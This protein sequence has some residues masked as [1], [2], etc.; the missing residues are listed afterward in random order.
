MTT[1][2]ET[3]HSADDEASRTDES[4]SDRPV[5]LVVEDQPAVAET[6][7][8]MLADRYTVRVATD[9]GAAL[10]ALSTGV[11]VVLLDRTMPGISGEEILAEIRDRGSECRMA[12]VTAVEPDVDIVEM[13][14][15]A[16]VQKPPTRAELVATVEDLLRRSR[17]AAD[18]RNYCTALSKQATLAAAEKPMA[19]HPEYAT[20]VADIEATG[21]R[22][23]A[24]AVDLTDDMAFLSV[25]RH[26][27][28]TPGVDA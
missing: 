18:L 11:D 23:Q 1:D 16:Y 2:D 12:M 20:L 14:F 10:A 24:A 25:I 3:T 28:E 17:Y 9:G 27:D 8:Q 26:I 4:E 13:G 6:Y 5:V 15:D 7:R 22:L 21:E 19:A